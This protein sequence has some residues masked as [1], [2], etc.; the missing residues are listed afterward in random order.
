M[1][2]F[3]KG[4]NLKVASLLIAIVFCLNAS[5]Y[6]I[7]TQQKSHLRP[8]LLGDSEEGKERLQGA[9]TVIGDNELQERLAL[10]RKFYNMEGFAQLETPL[11]IEG[12]V[13]TPD[14]RFGPTPPEAIE[15]LFSR[16]PVAG[17]RFMSLGAGEGLDLVEAAAHGAK[18]ARGYETNGIL[19]DRARNITNRLAAD[20]EGSKFAS[21]ITLYDT[22]MFKA[23]WKEAD[24]LYYFEN[25]SYREGDIEEKALK[26][27]HPGAILIVHRVEDFKQEKPLFFSRL[28][29]VEEFS[30]Y[31]RA[32]GKLYFEIYQVPQLREPDQKLASGQTIGPVAEIVGEN[33]AKIFSKEFNEVLLDESIGGNAG[34]GHAAVNGAI[35]AEGKIIIFG[36]IQDLPQH[37]RDKLNSG[38]LYNFGIRVNVQV[39]QDENKYGYYVSE[40][41][42]A[43]VK[44]I[45][46]HTVEIASK[47]PR[48]QR[49]EADLSF[50]LGFIEQLYKGRPAQKLVS[51]G[52][53]LD[54]QNN[55][56]V[57]IRVIREFI[58]RHQEF[59]NAYYDE[60]NLTYPK[61]CEIFCGIV[62]EA[63]EKEGIDVYAVQAPRHMYLLV[64]G[65]MEDGSTKEV[66]IDY[67]AD[68]IF[69]KKVSPLIGTRDDL[70]NQFP[71]IYGEAGRVLKVSDIKVDSS[72][73][74]YASLFDIVAK[75][76]E[77]GEKPDQEPLASNLSI[78]FQELK[79]NRKEVDSGL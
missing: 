21:A 47:I 68:Q 27:L 58:D 18:S 74:I 1:K 56:P 50:I 78:N 66:V 53:S 3:Y 38:E 54:S 42:P 59:K 7:D 46:R 55:R 13:E 39:E 20:P 51:A 25:G 57:D 5:V 45:L 49:L 31:L 15:Q 17:L 4:F 43:F 34:E 79:V 69:G 12:G 6:G 26:E 2:R 28:E 36:N 37:I 63:M 73:I 32:A 10:I 67:T 9:L 65:V 14:G 64:L 70:K 44:R 33:V 19:L 22:D 40:R 75:W 11:A 76:L 24:M 60:K 30:V 35:D 41:T 16:I 29:F 72:Y 52:P 71:D 62:G 61:G 8:N 48:K 77:T 23:S